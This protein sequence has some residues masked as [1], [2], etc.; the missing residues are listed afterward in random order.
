[1]SNQPLVSVIINCYNSD[2]Y[3]KEAIDSVLGQ[4]YDNWEIIFWDNQS[5]DKS[6]EIVK[7]YDDERIKYFYA[8]THTTLGEGRNKA[9]EKVSGEFISFLDCDDLYLPQKLEKT[10]QAFKDENIGLVYTN[11]YTLYE[12]KNIKKTF[13]NKKQLSGELFE[14]WLSSYQ[15][16]IPSVMFRKEVL[17]SLDYWFDNRFNMIEEF[18]FFMR[19]AKK[20]NINYYH[21]NL[22]IW[23]VH[24]ASMTWSKKELFEKEYKIFLTDLLSQNLKL[25]NKDYIKKFQAKIAYHEFYNNWVK[26]KK[27]KREILSPFFKIE[28]KLI[29]VYLL[30][31]FGLNNFHKFLNKIGKNV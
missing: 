13:Y 21:E 2:K 20:W 17:N 19:I 15:V 14:F 30:S 18:D 6:A 5:T 27:A 22:C 16:M 1:M 25:K 4:T 3:L 23:R 31:F 24:S 28:K 8:P 29:L 9:L 11:G 12:D 10:L 7:L 26:T